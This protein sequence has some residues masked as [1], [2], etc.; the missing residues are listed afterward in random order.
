MVPFGRVEAFCI[1]RK[2]GGDA[3]LE[4]GVP[5]QCK[6]VLGERKQVSGSGCYSDIFSDPCSRVERQKKAFVQL[7]SLWGGLF[8]P[9]HS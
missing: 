5:C 4:V 6:G 2:K 8:L 7:R 1:M 3:G 9:V